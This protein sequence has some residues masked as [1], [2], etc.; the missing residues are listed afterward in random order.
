MVLIRSIAMTVE[1]PVT[2]SVCPDCL[3]RISARLVTENETVYL[4]KEC[5]EHGRFKVVVWRG[6]PLFSEWFR[7]KLRYTGGVREEIRKGCPYDCGL[8][9]RHDQRTCSALVEITPRCN[10][11]CPV[12]FADSGSAENEPDLDTLKK[13]FDAIMERTGGCN[14]QL[15]GGE[16]TVRDDLDNIVAAARAAGFSFIQVNSNGIRFAE[17]P[18]YGKLLEDAGLST[19]FLQ[20]DGIDDQVSTIIRGRP[21]F[22]VK[23]RAIEHLTMTGVGVVLVPTLVPKINTGQLWDIVQFGIERLP[24]VRGVHF[25]PISYFGRFPKHFIPEHVTL[26][27]VIYALVT[28]SDGA[29]RMED[30]QPPGCEHALCSFSARYLIA[31][32]GTLQFLGKPQCRSAPEPAEQGALRSIAVTARQWRGPGTSCKQTTHGADDDL[33][34]FLRRAR[35]HTFSIS[36]MAFQDCWSMNLERLQGCCIHV[37]Q[38]DGRLI[39]FCSF[40]LTSRNGVPLHRGRQAVVALT[41]NSVR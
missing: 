20:F 36:G 22:T 1:L 26:P 9:A 35:T 27:E 7:P 14:L 41:E 18:S 12:C 2:E 5:P 24:G 25:Q 21:L 40:N 30:F 8:C 19:V 31:E 32:D 33:S 10:L 4:E 17:D 3:Q 13:M 34:R 16:P 11:H 37:A 28:Q 39:P 29:V 23:S 15:S 38:P 6:K